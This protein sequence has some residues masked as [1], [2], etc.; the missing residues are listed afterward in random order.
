MEAKIRRQL[1][2]GHFSSEAIVRGAIIQEAINHPG[3]IV[4]GAIF[5]RGNCP[6]T[7]FLHQSVPLMSLFYCIEKTQHF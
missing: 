6:R 5:V 2:G 3:A 7:L 1:S 4:R